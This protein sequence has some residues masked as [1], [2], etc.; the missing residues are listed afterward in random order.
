MKVVIIIVSA[1]TV[2]NVVLL[3]YSLMKAAS[4]ADDQLERDI[5]QRRKDGEY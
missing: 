2:L 1:L 4:D 3:V 5:E